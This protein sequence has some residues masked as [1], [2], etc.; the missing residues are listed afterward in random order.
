VAVVAA[1]LVGAAVLV[2]VTTRLLVTVG[3]APSNLTAGR[4][5]LAHASR[6]R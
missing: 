6:S 4:T 2:A 1:H 5:G 3:A